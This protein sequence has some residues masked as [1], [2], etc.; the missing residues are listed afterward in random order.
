MKVLITTSG[1]G[2][3]LGDLT[4]YT[5]KALI[6][7]G[8]KAVIS[9]IID[10]Y[11]YADFVITLGYLGDYV[12]QYLEIAHPDRNFEFVY[13]DPYSGPGSGLI[14]SLSFARNLL[15][16][17]FIFH[18]CDT[19]VNYKPN[20]TSNWM[21]CVESEQSDAFRTVRTT[22]NKI[23]RINEKGEIDYDFA[24]IGVAGIIDY[25]LFWEIVDSLLTGYIED[26]SDCHILMEMLNTVSINLVKIDDWDDTGGVERLNKAKQ[27][28]PNKY[29]VL[30]K[31][32]EAIYFVNNTVIKFFRNSTI[33]KN[34]VTRASA[35]RTLVP[36]ITSSTE[37][38]YKYPL[39]NGV[40][41][42]SD[43]TQERISNLVEWAKQNLWHPV[44]VDSKTF[45][46][47]CYEF[48]KEKTKG[49]IA[50]FIKNSNMPDRE[51]VINNHTVPSCE[52][53]LSQVDWELLCETEPTC[54]HGDFI[55]DN[56]LFTLDSFVLL[57]WRQ[58]F[59]GDVVAGDKYYDLSKLNHNLT[60]NHDILTQGLF[61]IDITDKAIK[62][63]VLR[64]HNM[65]QC[66]QFYLDA[67]AANG[68]NLNKIEVLTPLIWL[69]MSPLHTYPLNNFL[70]YFG[71]YN[72]W[73]AL[74]GNK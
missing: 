57:D 6:K 36:E 48:Y 53:L 19:I 35:L 74:C 14:K 67:L 7:L 26:S 50:K 44:S 24:Y 3:R 54:F 52:S 69:N 39:A 27:K 55:L 2:T 21:A 32:E 49:R 37:N 66:Q 43:I 38:F 16:T 20:L 72:L 41:L 34:R 51:C 29:N 9:H 63:D 70:F 33:C 62:C 59:A 42:A 71:R 73:R 46:G 4:K 22:N 1:L 28:H 60:L 15:Q 13:V 18:A 17:P 12:K 47:K 40:L 58:D 25:R 5:N 10:T 30:D 8:D 56:I 65:V 61:T 64:S 45:K 68:F 11:P 31:P 23:T